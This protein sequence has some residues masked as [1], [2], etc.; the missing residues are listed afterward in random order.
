MLSEP[1]EMLMPMKVKTA[2]LEKTKAQVDTSL[3]AD[4][5]QFVSEQLHQESDDMTFV[6][7]MSHVFDTESDP[8]IM[9]VIEEPPMNDKDLS[10]LGKQEDASMTSF[11][12]LSPVPNSDEL[13]DNNE[14]IEDEE[15]LD[16]SVHSTIREVSSINDDSVTHTQEMLPDYLKPNHYYVPKP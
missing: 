15:S 4:N 9:D 1:L 11:Q 13:I 5:E 16:A 10:N 7:P 14:L 6:I 8:V 3:L 2:P 12:A